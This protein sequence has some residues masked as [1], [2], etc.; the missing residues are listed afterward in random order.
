M[1]LNRLDYPF[2]N[3][4]NDCQIIV[5]SEE[6]PSVVLKPTTSETTISLRLAPQYSDGI[7]TSCFQ[8]KRVE[9]IW[10]ANLELDVQILI[11]SLC[12]NES[13]P[14]GIGKLYQSKSEPSSFKLT[15]YNYSTLE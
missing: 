14:E 13:S 1:I 8:W 11:D 6:L 7:K 9:E 5:L 15:V 4:M 12:H 10:T 2:R 3:L